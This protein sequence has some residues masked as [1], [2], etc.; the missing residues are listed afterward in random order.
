MRLESNRGG[1]RE[2]RIDSSFSFAKAA[3][4]SGGKDNFS[5]FLPLFPVHILIC[6][7]GPATPDGHT[8][9]FGVFQG[10]FL[11]SKVSKGKRKERTRGQFPYQ[12][13]S[14]LTLHWRRTGGR[15]EKENMW[16]RGHS[17]W[18]SVLSV[19]PM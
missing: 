5:F 18:L 3:K 13:D 14:I 2:K 10:W 19:L 11:S 17:F 16:P 1:K 9:Q 6:A 12:T 7:K 4:D 8:L 15:E